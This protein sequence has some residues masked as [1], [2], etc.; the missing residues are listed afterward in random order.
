MIIVDHNSDPYLS[1][2]TNNV[3]FHH[4]DYAYYWDDYVHGY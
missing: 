2:I 1:L 4:D 3:F